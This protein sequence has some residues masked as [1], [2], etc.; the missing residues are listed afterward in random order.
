MSGK[1]NEVEGKVT[2]EPPRKGEKERM[3]TFLH[4]IPN[5]CAYCGPSVQDVARQ[6]TVYRNG[7]PDTLKQFLLEHRAA[8]GLLVSVERFAQTRARLET[9]GTAETILF[10][11]VQAELKGEKK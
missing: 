4:G 7:L 1:E 5:P 3:E 6:F 2:Q 8:R 11:K 10:H 9:P